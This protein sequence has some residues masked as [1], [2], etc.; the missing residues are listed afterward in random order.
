M[1]ENKFLLKSC[2]TPTQL[3]LDTQ[4]FVFRLNKNKLQCKTKRFLIPIR[5]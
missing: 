4:K 2:K 1:N 5:V 3:L